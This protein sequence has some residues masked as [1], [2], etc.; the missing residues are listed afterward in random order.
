MR[1]AVALVFMAILA[2][3][4]T[5][6]GTDDRWAVRRHIDTPAGQAEMA[7]LKAEAEERSARAAAEPDTRRQRDARYSACLEGNTE[8]KHS[9]RLYGK[10]HFESETCT[11]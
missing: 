3:C 7:K 10:T 8:R 4:V 1:I 9:A 6:G 2:G 11:W 5:D